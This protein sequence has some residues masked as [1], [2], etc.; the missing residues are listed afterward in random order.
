[1]KHLTFCA[2]LA[3]VPVGP[4]LALELPSHS[5]YDSRVKYVS[6]NPADVVQIDTVI[7]V[8]TMI[9]LEAG[10]QYQTHAFG[11]SAAYSFSKSGNYIFLK[12][13]AENA[14]TN[15][16]VVTD[17]R[18]YKFRLSFKG[19]RSGATYSLAFRYPDTAARAKSAALRE[20]QVTQAFKVN[21]ASANLQY[22][23]SGDTEIAPMN[24]WD[25]GRF[26]YL[27]FAANQD[28]PTVYIVNVEGK[29]SIVNFTTVGKS[30]QILKVH[31][32]H[33]KFYIRAGNRV[34]ALFNEAYDS[35]GIPNDTGTASP[36]VERVVKGGM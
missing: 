5:K 34:L 2:L 23:M 14:N 25:D 24:V 19:D 16:L 21:A 28:M 33:P 31:K 35:V 10:E 18:A 6:Y 29:E 27:K 1:M 13:S 11:D 17:R 22:T 4:A 26:T 32:V 30:N 7:G 20:A 15:L 12:P 3:F 36:A 8:A 9:E